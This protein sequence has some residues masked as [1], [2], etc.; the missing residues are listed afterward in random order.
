MNN[1]E[2][3]INKGRKTDITSI[4][5]NIFDRDIRPGLMINSFNAGFKKST[6][7]S[8]QQPSVSSDDLEVVLY[9][10]TLRIGAQNP[11]GKH[12]SADNKPDELKINKPKSVFYNFK[13]FD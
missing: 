7:Y 11:K 8:F 9:L 3:F 10:A 1:S 13:L 12:F 6:K 5:Q 4:I 2:Q